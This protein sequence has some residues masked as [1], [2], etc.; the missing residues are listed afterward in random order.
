MK[1]SASLFLTDI[2][3]HKRGWFNK[4][5]KTPI[6]QD[7]T[8]QEVFATLKASGIEGIELLLP[9]FA[10]VTQEDI[11]QLKK[12]LAE[13]HMPVFSVHQS[14]R[15]LTQTKSEEIKDLFKIAD[16]LSAKV[17]VLHMNSAGKQIFDKAYIDM[18]HALEKQY[19][20]KAGFE[21]REK[22]IGSIL[23]PY[24][25]HEDK[26]SSLMKKQNFSITLDTTHLAQAGGDIINF[27]KKNKD[28]IVNI[29]LSDYRPHFLNSSLRPLRFKHLP[30]GKGQ[31]PIEEFLR[32]L[33]KENY[34]GLVTMEINTDLPGMCESAKIITDNKK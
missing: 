2:M 10:R 32:I 26:F 25:W 9:S 6:F 18:I 14:I 19:G 4:I 34:K 16:K 29:H 23:K 8:P 21:N 7:K 13:N 5:V 31:L 3:P 20:I 30:L 17:V 22:F 12:F 33:K 24:G 1:T 11:N 27:F 15:F 28:R